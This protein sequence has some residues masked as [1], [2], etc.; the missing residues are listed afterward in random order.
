MVKLQKREYTEQ[1]LV[2][3]ICTDAQKKSYAEKNRFRGGKQRADFR[4]KLSAYCEYEFDESTRKYTITNIFDIPK[5]KTQEKM[6]RGIYS[7]I[8]PLILDYVV[9]SHNAEKPIQTTCLDIG[10][11]IGMVNEN[12]NLIKYNEKLR[13]NLDI[14]S[15]IFNEY[16]NKVDVQ[17]RDYI[18]RCLEYLSGE[19]Y[20][21]ITD[22]YIIKTSEIKPE[23]KNGGENV[24][25]TKF[26]QKRVATDAEIELYEGIVKRI[27]AE[28]GAY[29]VYEKHY[30]KNSKAYYILL[31][32]LLGEHCVDNMYKGIDIKCLNL[33]KCEQMLN[34]FKETM[35]LSQSRESLRETF[36]L[37]VDKNTAARVV[38]KKVD[39]EKY[40]EFFSNLTAL[41]ISSEA[42]DIRNKIDEW[43]TKV[44][45]LN[46]KA[47]S[48]K[49][50]YREVRTEA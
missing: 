3:K 7:Y 41:T 11:R 15:R 22:I 33:G 30:G 45:R 19:G 37:I 8:T 24:V 6:T 47:S 49:V 23:I 43:E 48:I 17:I 36:R 14:P 35:T 25:V 21:E 46:R 38:K 18:C 31:R 16:I 34:T 1:A 13:K 44:M 12:Y 20:I 42:E 40:A 39:D 29:T 27:E 2:D 28:T 50:T 10:S 5:N 4:K 9:D 26:E 32:K